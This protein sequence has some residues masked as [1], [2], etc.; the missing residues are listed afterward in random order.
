MANSTDYNSTVYIGLGSNQNSPVEQLHSAINA[1]KQ[2]LEVT[3]V[4]CSALYGSKP[5]GPQDQP[6]FVNAVAELTTS[7]SPLALLQ[8][9][10]SIEQIHGRQRDKNR[11]GPRTLDLDILLF[12][13]SIIELPD[14]I[15]PHYGI[16]ER[17]FVLYPLLEIAADLV[18]PD[19]SKIADLAKNCDRRGLTKLDVAIDISH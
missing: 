1:L 10:Q 9:L 4:R 16:S 14:L 18:M 7:L 11:W 12:G 2:S 13:D 19:G 17:E 5:M 6:D 15:V 8:Y 3:L